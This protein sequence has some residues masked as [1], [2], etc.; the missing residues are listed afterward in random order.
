MCMNIF[1]NEFRRLAYYL[2]DTTLWIVFLTKEI[3]NLLV[4]KTPFKCDNLPLP[5]GDLSQAVGLVV[6]CILNG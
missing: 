2:Q 4:L 1:M 5:R 6:A 3:L